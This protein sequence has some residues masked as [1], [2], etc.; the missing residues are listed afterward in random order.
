VKAARH[1]AANTSGAPYRNRALDAMPNFFQL[2][3]NELDA[4]HGLQTGT[5]ELEADDPVWETL[6]DRGLVVLRRI[7]RNDADASVT[8]R[9]TLTLL[10][11]RYPTR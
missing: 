4:L 10:G 7:M 3:E 11:R 9:A 2:N 1:S 8:R 6:E 5:G